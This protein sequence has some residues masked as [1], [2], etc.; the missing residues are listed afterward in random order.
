MTTLIFRRSEFKYTTDSSIGIFEGLR[1]CG[2]NVLSSFVTATSKD[3]YTGTDYCLLGF[4]GS[5]VSALLDGNTRTAWANDKSSAETSC[6]VIDFKSNKFLLQNYMLYSVCNAV[7]NWRIYG[8]NDMQNWDLVDERKDSAISLNV[9]NFFHANK[10]NKG[11]RYFKYSDINIGRIHLTNIEFYG[12]LNPLQAQITCNQV[13]MPKLS[14]LFF[15]L[16]F[17]VY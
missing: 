14:F 17:Y 2:S 10:T 1:N 12:I 7:K 4:S 15:S 16:F 8:S 9:K 5:P 11:F 13:K 3:R 6:F